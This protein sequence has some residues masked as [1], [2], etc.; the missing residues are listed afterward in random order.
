[1]TLSPRVVIFG[2]VGLVLA[3][4]TSWALYERAGKYKAWASI[5]KLSAQVVIQN[6]AVEEWKAAADRAEAAMW[7]ARVVANKRAT[8]INA[9]RAKLADILRK[10]RPDGVNCDA[11]WGQI[12]DIR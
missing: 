8:I 3:G 7:E 2:I 10:K 9:E 4:L 6:E 5:E 12:E 11:A 1:M